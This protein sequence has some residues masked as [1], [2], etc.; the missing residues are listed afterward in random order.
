MKLAMLIG[1]QNSISALVKENLPINVKWDL[2]LFISKISPELTAFEELKNAKI[3]EYGEEVEKEIDGKMVKMTQVKQENMEVFTKEINE[4]LEKEVDV[5]IP[6]IKIKEII[7]YN[8]VLIENK[9]Q[10]IDL[11]I[12]DLL[13]LDWLIK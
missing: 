10:P 5:I 2:K 4:L 9:K 1:S 6:D 3:L 11:L 13:V 8:K 12:S 7:E